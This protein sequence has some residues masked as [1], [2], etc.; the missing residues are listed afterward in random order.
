M[1]NVAVPKKNPLKG[2]KVPAAAKK[3]L[4]K[5]KI[6]QLDAARSRSVIVRRKYDWDAIREYFISEQQTPT[7]KA[8]A[9]KFGVPYDYLRERAAKERWSYLRAQEQQRIFQEKRKE[10]LSRMARE[11]VK[12]DE[13]VIDVAKLGMSLVAGRLAEI[14]AEFQASQ[15]AHQIVVEKLRRG[16]PVDWKE[17]RSVI[18][19][20]ELAELSRAGLAFQDMGMKAFGTDVQKVEIE[21]I[22][23]TNIE[24]VINV[25]A[26]LSK[27]DPS[28]LAAL[29][30]A[31][32]R[33]GLAQVNL[34]EG[35]V[36]EGQVV[37]PKQ[38][39]ANPTDAKQGSE[40]SSDG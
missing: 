32:E 35:E 3:P 12:F 13:S 27:D 22:G 38:L 17:L 6:A 16:E 34:D 36:I 21:G 20:K 14:A 7:L 18:N 33:A 28:R 24:T 1:W 39:E 19:Y 26:E 30:D 40:E 29:L 23:G 11:S 31:L 15:T 25:G 10:H 5:A 4:S 8:V 2:A 37:E 9:E